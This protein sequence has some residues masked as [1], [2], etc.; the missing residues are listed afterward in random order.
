M[1]HKISFFVSK[2]KMILSQE[3]QSSPIIYKALQGQPTIGKMHNRLKKLIEPLCGPLNDLLPN[4]DT[5]LKVKV[6]LLVIVN[7]KKLDV[8]IMKVYWKFKNFVDKPIDNQ[9]RV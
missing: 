4:P 8:K 3:T 7:P 9:I 5:I 1:K 6:V 2:G